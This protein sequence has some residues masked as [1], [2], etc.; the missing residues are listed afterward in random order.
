M[1]KAKPHWSR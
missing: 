1:A